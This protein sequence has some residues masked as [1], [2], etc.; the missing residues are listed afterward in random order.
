MGTRETRG[1]EDYK[2]KPK[3]NHCYGH[4]PQAQKGPYSRIQKGLKHQTLAWN[5]I[6]FVTNLSFASAVDAKIGAYTLIRLTSPEDVWSRRDRIRSVPSAGGV[7]D[8][9]NL[10]LTANPIPCSLISSDGLPCQNTVKSL[11]LTDHVSGS[12]VS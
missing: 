1:D 10:F 7:M 5:E 11:S 4:T 3:G 6:R 8:S 2:V 9:N 12:L